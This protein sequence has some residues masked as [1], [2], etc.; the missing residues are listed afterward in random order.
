MEGIEL[1]DGDF[2]QRVSASEHTVMIN[3]WAPWCKTCKLIRPIVCEIAE[4]YKDIIDVFFVN[5]DQN[6]VVKERFRI[7]GAP[8]LVLIDPKDPNTMLARTIG[9]PESRR[10]I[11]NWLMAHNIMV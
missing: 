6:P 5:I 1:T 2:V 11:L 10:Q 9:Q 7:M 8:V 4:E 3:M